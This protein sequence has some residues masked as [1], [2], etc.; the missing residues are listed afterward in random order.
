MLAKKSTVIN[1]EEWEKSK[2]IRRPADKR[3]DIVIFKKI[4]N[5]ANE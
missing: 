1:T 5:V 4:T 3:E 2:L